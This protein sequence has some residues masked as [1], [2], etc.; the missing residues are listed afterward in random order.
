MPFKCS[1]MS[2]HP[3]KKFG[4]FAFHQ[5]CARAPKHCLNPF[6]DKKILMPFLLRLRELYVAYSRSR[7]VT[8]RTRI[9]T[10]VCLRSKLC[11]WTL[12]WHCF[13]GRLDSRGSLQRGKNDYNLDTNLCLRRAFGWSCSDLPLPCCMS[14]SYPLSGP[15]FPHL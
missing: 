6:N 11:L 1:Q 4:Q 3:A 5:Q 15:Q 10:K 9:W 13:P 8:G 14:K 2:D 12:I 7:Q